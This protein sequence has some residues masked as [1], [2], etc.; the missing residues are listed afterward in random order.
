M[1]DVEVVSRVHGSVTTGIKAEWN[2]NTDSKSNQA[3]SVIF[4]ETSASRELQV[5]TK[6][7]MDISKQVDALKKMAEGI[8][9]L[10]EA[11]AKSSTAILELLQVEKDRS[12]MNLLSM[13]WT[14][15]LLKKGI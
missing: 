1:G 11:L 2:T 9:M 14:E 3:V 15:S 6:R 7:C 5:G 10:V 4:P 12:M 13:L 8:D